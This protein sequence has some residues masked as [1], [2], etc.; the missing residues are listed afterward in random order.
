MTASIT[1]GVLT[2]LLLLALALPASTEIYKITVE[3]LIPGGPSRR[4]SR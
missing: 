1:R 2:T 3:N 4:V